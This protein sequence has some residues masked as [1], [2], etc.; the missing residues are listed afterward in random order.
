L[1]GHKLCTDRRAAPWELVAAP[2]FC[3]KRC[4]KVHDFEDSELGKV[5]PYGV[6]DVGANAGWVSVG[7]MSN[8]A[9][10]AVA[11]IRRWLD[12][13]GRERYPEAAR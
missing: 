11:S 7:V 4:V 8:T 6:Y 1:F 12:A 5:V 10:F 13:M 2:R 9:Q 3:R